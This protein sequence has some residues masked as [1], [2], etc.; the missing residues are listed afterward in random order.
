MPK[1]TRVWSGISVAPSNSAHD[2]AS[3]SSGVIG[4]P[5]VTGSSVRAMPDG[6]S[7]VRETTVARAP[8]AVSAEATSIAM[9]TRAAL[10]ANT[11]DILVRPHPA[12][13]VP[14]GGQQASPQL[15]D[16]DISM[17]R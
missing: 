9:A 16:Y 1:S 13:S 12:G 6:S 7:T 14:D 11:A 17:R 8:A 10:L 5:L 2:V 3:V 15:Q 4:T